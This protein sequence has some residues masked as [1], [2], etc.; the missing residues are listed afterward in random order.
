LR[1]ATGT[2]RC[3]VRTGSAQTCPLRGLR[4]CAALIRPALRYSPAHDGGR[5]ERG[6]LLRQLG[7]RGPSPRPSPPEERGSEGT[8]SERGSPLPSVPCGRAEQR[9]GV[10]IR[11]SHVRRPR[12]GQVCE[13]PPRREQ[14]KEPRSGPDFGSP[15][16]C[17][18]FLGETKKRRSPA[19][20]RP[21]QTKPQDKP[22]TGEQQLRAPEGR[23]AE[24]E[25]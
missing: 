22:E 13:F 18:L 21:G 15:F 12:S 2:L 5:R 20:A 17:L 24:C 19:G 14:R 23:D 6:H 16:F 10:G 9:R 7:W 4:T 3:S 25:A 8:V 1:C 11:N